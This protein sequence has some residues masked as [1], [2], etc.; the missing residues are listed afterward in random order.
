VAVSSCNFLIYKV[1][2]KQNCKEGRES[3]VIRNCITNGMLPCYQRY[4][5]TQVQRT[6]KLADVLLRIA[7]KEMW[8]AAMDETQAIYAFGKHNSYEEQSD[9]VRAFTAIKHLKHCQL[10]R[11]LKAV[12]TAISEETKHYYRLEYEYNAI[13]NA[14]T[15]GLPNQLRLEDAEIFGRY[16]GFIS[17]DKLKEQREN[18]EKL[19]MEY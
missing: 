17:K 18:T 15:C 19:E 8:N 12:R 10:I 1:W 7:C 9:K 2:L 4:L 6:E 11:E 3:V 14:I 5:Q 16:D 13:S